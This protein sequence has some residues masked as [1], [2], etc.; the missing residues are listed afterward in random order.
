MSVNKDDLKEGRINDQISSQLETMSAQVEASVERGKNALEEWS[1]TL[2]DK[3]AELGRTID[4]YSR[5]HPW[6]MVSSAL[7]AGLVLGLLLGCKTSGRR[8]QS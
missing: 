7:V 4:R 5:E 1:A 6:R 2:S 8:A 3:S